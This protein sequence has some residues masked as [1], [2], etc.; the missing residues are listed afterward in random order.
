MSMLDNVDKVILRNIQ[1]DG[2]ITNV[3]LAQSAGISAP[4]C[5][6]RLKLMEDRNIIMSY[7]AD[8]NPASLGYFVRATCIVQ[9]VSQSRVE[10]EKFLKAIKNSPNIRTCFA[11]SGDETFVL[12]IVAK[13][14]HD[15]EYILKTQIQ[16]CGV[17]QNLKSY[18][19]LNTYKE[20]HG[21]P[22]EE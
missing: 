5:L 10:F 21:I 17:V 4:P 14:L 6:R 1:N 3:K 7:H 22:I 16:A 15:Y 12:T 13:D 18:I 8:I 2:R 11:T 19:T 9:L 20:E